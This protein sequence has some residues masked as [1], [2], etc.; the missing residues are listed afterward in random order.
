MLDKGMSINFTSTN[1][2]LPYKCYLNVA[3]VEATKTLVQGAAALNKTNVN[4][5]TQLKLA[6]S[7]GGLNILC[8]PTD[9]VAD[10]I[11]CDV[12]NTTTFQLDV[13]SVS[14]DR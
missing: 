14:V 3:N 12:K 4:G 9:S 13:F 11:I 8:N 1:I 6:E 5:D 7:C 10:N 2:S